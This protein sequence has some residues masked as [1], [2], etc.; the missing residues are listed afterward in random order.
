MKNADQLAGEYSTFILE[1]FRRLDAI[2]ESM[3]EIKANPDHPSN[4][5]NFDF[6]W[7]QI[8]KICEY[9]ALAIVLAH[10]RG[11]TA[12]DDLSKWRPSDLLKQIENLNAHPTPVQ[13]ANE[14]VPTGDGERQL[15]PLAKGIDAKK[16]SEIYGR[17]NDVL[18]VG[19]LSRILKLKIPTYEVSQLERWW[20]GFERLLRNHALL[21]PQVKHVLVCLH[22][23]GGEAPPQI[24]LMRGEGEGIFNTENLPEF[25]LEVA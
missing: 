15:I 7:F 5:K 17:C 22:I 13:I 4:W 10:H 3:E 12:V 8:R 20:S 14:L 23:K 16:I 24:F 2:A 6:C 1:I 9:L 25:E 21:L 18:H 19:T 11:A